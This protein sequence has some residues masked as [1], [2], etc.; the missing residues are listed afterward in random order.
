MIVKELGQKH[1]TLKTVLKIAGLAKS[2][3]YDYINAKHKKE[4]QELLD[5]IHYIWLKNKKRYGYRR[6]TLALQNMGYKIN[7]KRV[8]RLMS[9]LRIKGEIRRKKYNSYQGEV[10][11]IADNEL[12]RQFTSD[13]FGAKLVTDITEFNVA[14]RKVYLSPLIDLCNR[15]VIS[16]TISLAA[17]TKLVIDMLKGAEKN[18]TDQTMI[19]SDQGVQYQSIGYQKYLKEHNI[20][21]SMS[22]RGNC[23]D[24]SLAENFFSHVKA[25]FFH[26][27]KFKT[28]KQFIRELIEYIKYYNE[29][30]IIT[31]LKMS[32]VQYREHCLI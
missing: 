1:G 17:N 21:L 25:E 32:P 16:Y 12:N 5:L 7:H 14:G 24:N 9:V 6:I 18:Y 26:R 19:H 4:N 3:Y 20:T 2:T 30:R 11:R 22:R 15:E 10:G 8:K 28:V 27:C 29:E 23:Y 31:K 13:T